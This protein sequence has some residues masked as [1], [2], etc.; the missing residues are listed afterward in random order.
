MS[1]AVCLLEAPRSS[2]EQARNLTISSALI[3]PRNAKPQGHAIPQPYFSWE[4]L[5]ARVIQEIS[6]G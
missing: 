1:F 2:V 3:D 6:Q 5:G 4:F